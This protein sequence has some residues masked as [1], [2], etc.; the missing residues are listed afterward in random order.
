[1]VM[2]AL[3]M[4]GALALPYPA[5]DETITAKCYLD[6][7]IGDNDA[8]GR[9]VIGLFGNTV[10]KTTKNF[11]KWMLV[12]VSLL[13]LSTCGLMVCVLRTLFDALDPSTWIMS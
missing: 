3:F 6:V 11:L 7:V 10:P 13:V 9:I 2:F 5:G 4:S 1:M 8:R 12:K